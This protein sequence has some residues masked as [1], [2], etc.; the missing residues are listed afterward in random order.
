MTRLMQCRWACVLGLASFVRPLG[1]GIRYP[2][3]T[4]N[5]AVRMDSL[6]CPSATIRLIMLMRL[7][8]LILR[9]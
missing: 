3:A 9:P 4:M 5:L 8:R 6:L 1:S 2:E 7:L